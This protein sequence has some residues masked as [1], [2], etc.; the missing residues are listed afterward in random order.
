MSSNPANDLVLS[1][2][3]TPLESVT[4]SP[5]LSCPLSPQLGLS[6]TL[7]RFLTPRASKVQK[8]SSKSTLK[9]A[10]SGE[11]SIKCT[12]SFQPYHSYDNRYNRPPH[13]QFMSLCMEKSDMLAPL[14]TVGLEPSDQTSFSRRRHGAR[15]DRD[16]N[17]TIVTS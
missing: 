2:S 9:M 15:S 14:D 7:N 8:W 17:V 11:P 13:P 16:Y 5:W 6:K 1:I 12:S 10:S 4:P 3:R